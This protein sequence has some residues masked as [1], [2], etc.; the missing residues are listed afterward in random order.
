MAVAGWGSLLLNSTGTGPPY[1]L[2]HF[3]FQFSGVEEAMG[4]SVPGDFS[5]YT[6]GEFPALGDGLSGGKYIKEFALDLPE[7]LNENVMMGMRHPVLPYLVQ[8]QYDS[9][10]TM[11]KVPMVTLENAKTKVYAAPEWGGKLWS[12]VDKATGKDFFFNNPWHQPCNNGNLKAY[13]GGGLEWNWSPGIVGHTVFT[14]SPV[15]MAKVA[16]DRGDVLRL[17]EFDRWNATVWQADVFLDDDGTL[18]THTK[19]TNPGPVD[20]PGYWWMNVGMET[21]TP[22]G[23]CRPTKGSL[24]EHLG[25]R[26]ITPARYS[27]AGMK[28]GLADWPSFDQSC[29]PGN[30]NFYGTDAH[31]YPDH[32]FIA[33]YTFFIDKCATSNRIRGSRALPACQSPVPEIS[34][35]F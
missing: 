4:I 20:V 19:V 7:Y 3:Q 11:T 33:N 30:M 34:R 25:S 17:Y 29:C 26:V 35:R 27:Y 28:T 1:L 9:N 16:T 21:T 24:N 31:S 13:T 12:V 18:Y 2:P 6:R 32:S 22:R 23:V 8:D 14:E 5:H 10:R 15:W